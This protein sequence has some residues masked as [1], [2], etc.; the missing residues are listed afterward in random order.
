MEATGMI[1][2]I[3]E[4]LLPMAKNRT[5]IV[6]CTV[7]TG[8]FLNAT[9]SDQYLSIIMDSDIYRELYRKKGFEMR[10][11]SRTVEDSA[12]VTSPLV[13]WGSCGM[14]Q[15]TILSVPTLVYAPFAFFCL[16]SP[17]MSIL[18]AAIGWKIVRHEPE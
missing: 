16:I 3:A 12:T 15:A 11:L 10:L 5:G 7:L 8:V 9:V 1:G 17:L 4:L 13:P 18:I 6:S 14:T 2:R